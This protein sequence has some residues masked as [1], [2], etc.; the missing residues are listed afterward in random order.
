M[1][2]FA[3]RECNTGL[4]RF[5]F[6]GRVKIQVI[7]DNR[8]MHRFDD[9]S[10]SPDPNF[11]ASELPKDYFLYFSKYQ[12]SC[13]KNL[14]IGENCQFDMILYNPADVN[15]DDPPLFAP[16]LIRVSNRTSLTYYTEDYIAEMNK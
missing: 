15:P 7:V 12:I 5:T 4:F 13:I 14:K 16:P 1:E 10:Y 3:E 9:N 8:T 11:V 6:N 2:F